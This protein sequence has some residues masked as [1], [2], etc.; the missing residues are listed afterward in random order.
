LDLLLRIAKIPRS[1]YYYHQKHFSD[2]DR[3]A[4]VRVEIR[5]ICQEHKG[6]YGY[7]RVTLTLYQLGYRTNHKLVM[8]LMAEEHLT[9][10]LRKKK[11]RSYR[12]EVGRVA[13]NLLK[14]NFKA[15]QPNQNG[16]RISR[17]SSC[18]DKNSIYPPSLIFSMA[19]SSA[20]PCLS[21]PPSP[22]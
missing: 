16:L 22:S 21:I 10:L 8:K 19:R 6:R 4:D 20:M 11:Y 17:N 5:R 7:R 13:P 12:G 2:K 1:S 3:H 15:T 18:L 9:C 14:R